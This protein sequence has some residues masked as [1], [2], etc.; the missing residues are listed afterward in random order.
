MYVTFIFTPSPPPFT[1]GTPAYLAP[2]IVQHKE[3]GKEVDWWY[4]EKEL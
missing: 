3:Y 2:E 1:S 4:V